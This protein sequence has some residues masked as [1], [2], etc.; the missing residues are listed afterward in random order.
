MTGQRSALAHTG[1]R[2]KPTRISG[3]QTREKILNSAE[4]L[5]AEQ[6]FDSVSLRDITL[7]AQVT[8]ALASY[9]FG[10]KE[11]LF[12]AVV[13]R[14]ADVL[15]DMR[16]ERLGRLAKPG[17]RDLLDAFMAPLFE[18]AGSDEPGWQDY[19]RVLAR[20]GERERWV[21]LLSRHFDATAHAFLEA[22]Q[23]ALAGADERD[24]ARA[25]TFV[26]EAMLKAV[27]Q[28]GR[29][30]KLTEGAA[31]ARDLDKAYPVLLR[32]TAAGLEAFRKL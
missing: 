17:V 15:R 1:R 30:D 28:H 3:D 19:L 23:K 29:L 21:E 4:A 26:L 11:A 27:S 32:F 13:A 10:S 8:L 2:P 20:L 16:L 7:K 24:V 31:S 9:H 14:R 12:E 25:F 22:L 5:F 6:S 18:M